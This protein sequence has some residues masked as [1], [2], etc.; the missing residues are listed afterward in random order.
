MKKILRRIFAVVLI[1]RLIEEPGKQG[2]NVYHSN[3]CNASPAEYADRKVG[4]I[5]Y[6]GERYDTADSIGKYDVDKSLGSCVSPHVKIYEKNTARCE[7]HH[8]EECKVDQN[9][10]ENERNISY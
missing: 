3:E 2:R 7:Y 6:E 4:D 9:I 10:R 5:L 1:K 8:G